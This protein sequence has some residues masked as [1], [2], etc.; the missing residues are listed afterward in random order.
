[1]VTSGF[2]VIPAI[3][4][5]H[6]TQSEYLILFSFYLLVHRSHRFSSYFQILFSAG[7]PIIQPALFSWFCIDPSFETNKIEI[8]R[9]GM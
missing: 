8:N 3:A 2:L 7:P 4:T 6:S 9:N 1:V 5:L